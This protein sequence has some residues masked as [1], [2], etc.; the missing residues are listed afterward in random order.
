MLLLRLEDQGAARPCLRSGS[1]KPTAG[2]ACGRWLTIQP[3]AR[4][5]ARHA[6]AASA[7]TA[8]RANPP[9]GP[10]GGPAHS[11]C[12][13][14]SQQDYSIANPDDVS[15][16]AF[17][18][19][20]PELTCLSTRADAKPDPDRSTTNQDEAPVSRRQCGWCTQPPRCTA[21]RALS[22]AAPRRASASAMPA[23][24]SAHVI[25]PCQRH[26]LVRPSKMHAAKSSVRTAAGTC[27]LLLHSPS[28]EFGVLRCTDSRERMKVVSRGPTF[29]ALHGSAIHRCNCR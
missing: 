23:L 9:R 24:R 20:T 27:H 3:G 8:G 6:R 2:S 14:I 26:V 4:Q 19:F 16:T 18:N 25:Q 11:S 12:I 17:G 5:L 21:L 13:C 29:A 1:S 22:S 7:P 10:G 28:Y 15:C